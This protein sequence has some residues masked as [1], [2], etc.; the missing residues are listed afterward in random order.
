[1]LT[2]PAR[3]VALQE[4][5]RVSRRDVRLIEP[6]RRSD[7]PTPVIWSRVLAFVRDRPLALDE[8]IE[9]GLVPQVL[10]RALLAG[11]YSMVRATKR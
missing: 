7:A 8:L 6:V 10:G 2:V 3:R 11:V 9:V 5:A 1:L 4:M